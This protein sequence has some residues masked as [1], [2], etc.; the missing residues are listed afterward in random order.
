MG[1]SK[2]TVVPSYGNRSAVLTWD[3]WPTPADHYFL[4]ERSWDGQTNWEPLNQQDDPRGDRAI[5]QYVDTGLTP[6]GLSRTAHY[7]LSATGVDQALGNGE[8]SSCFSLF[9]GIPPNQFGVVRGILNAETRNMRSG[10]G[11][12]LVVL[13]PRIFGTRCSC[14]DPETGQ[15]LG[16]SVC[17]TCMGTGYVGGFQ[18]RIR[19]FGR[20]LNATNVK[21]SYQDKLGVRDTQEQLLRLL[22]YPVLR[23]GN[24]IIQEQLDDRYVVEETELHRFRNIYPVTQHARVRLLSRDN[25]V[26]HF[27]L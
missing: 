12:E 5:L 14:T 22:A 11:S 17:P 27:K 15:E 23:R 18:S 24:I 10:N 4:V 19:T 3:F 26:Y 2:M 25:P 7:R 21:T 16:T 20:F 1:F 9:N 6:G 8:T 13:I